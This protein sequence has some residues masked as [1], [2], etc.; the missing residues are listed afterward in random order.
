MGIVEQAKEWGGGKQAVEY[1]TSHQHIL[2]NNTLS[3]TYDTLYSLYK[4]S[5]SYD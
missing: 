3:T 2:L 5:Q 1:R 4:V